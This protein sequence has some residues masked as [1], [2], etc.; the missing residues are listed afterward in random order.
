MV[1]EENLGNEMEDADD[2]EEPLFDLSSLGHERDQSQTGEQVTQ[3]EQGFIKQSM[4]YF[5]NHPVRHTVG[6]ALLGLGAISI[7][8][9][10]GCF[11]W[12]F[13]LL[14]RDSQ[15]SD[16]PVAEQKL[17][18][19]KSDLEAKVL[20]EGEIKGNKVRLLDAGDGLHNLGIIEEIGYGFVGKA[21][22]EYFFNPKTKEVLEIEREERRRNFTRTCAE[23]DCESED[24]I[25]RVAIREGNILVRMYLDAIEEKV[26]SDFGYDKTREKKERHSR[27]SV[28]SKRSRPKSELR[29]IFERD[30]DYRRPFNIGTNY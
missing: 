1:N 23:Y 13:Y 29:E 21:Y 27:R 17:L 26:A 16:R 2:L 11:S 30:K 20:W 24:P 14:S 5:F 28:K 25:S 22:S 9:C 7:A 6:I 8:T 19:E 10:G 15:E 18:E 4:K 3:N 12:P